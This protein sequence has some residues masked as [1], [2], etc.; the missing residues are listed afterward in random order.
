LD[1]SLPLVG[2]ASGPVRATGYG[3]S[4]E[5]WEVH[6][7]ANPSGIVNSFEINSLAVGFEALQPGNPFPDNG[8][9][10]VTTPTAAPPATRG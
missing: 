7:I 10:V 5:D 4:V 2:C 8:V 3:R 1:R 6:G 9:I